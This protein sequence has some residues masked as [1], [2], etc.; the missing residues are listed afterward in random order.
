M[1]LARL[2]LALGVLLLVGG[3]S[4]LH[5]FDPDAESQRLLRR[6]AEWADV[7]AAGRDVDRIASY[8]SD[9]AVIIPQGQPVVEGK[10][11]IRDVVEGDVHAAA[12]ARLVRAREVDGLLAEARVQLVDGR[13]EALL[14]AFGGEERAGM[15]GLAHEVGVGHSHL[16]DGSR[17]ARTLRPELLEH[18][19]ESLRV[20]GVDEAHL[21]APV[22]AVEVLHVDR[23]ARGVVAGLA[24]P[25]RR[26]LGE[27][28]ED[29]ER[30]LGIAMVGPEDARMRDRMGVAFALVLLFAANP[31]P[32]D[33]ATDPAPDGVHFVA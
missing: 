16:E 24:Q 12:V 2:T 5:P 29:R 30:V 18:V 4:T 13:V 9:D 27:P 3:C 7:A 31:A 26:L 19:E 14:P 15:P 33:V 25:H 21:R 10:A 22:A 11:A 1:K 6:D 23:H 8:W 20:L 28:V 17:I 32:H